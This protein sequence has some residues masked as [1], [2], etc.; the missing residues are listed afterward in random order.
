MD[1]D[2]E[3]WRHQWDVF[4]SAPYVI[5]P[6]LAIGWFIGQKL[7]ATKITNLKGTITNLNSRIAVLEERLG[8]AKDQATYAKDREEDVR[9]AN[10]VLEKE[11]DEYKALI[12]ANA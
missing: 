4:R 11:R 10:A 2:L 1:F 3:T 9:R 6:A 7:S 8:H 5:L 12:A